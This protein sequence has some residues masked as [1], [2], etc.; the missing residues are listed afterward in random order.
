MKRYRSIPANVSVLASLVITFAGSWAGG[1]GG[2]NVTSG[3]G[4]GGNGAGELLCGNGKLDT[5]EECD[6][7]ALNDDNAVCTSTCKKTHCGDGVVNT[8]VEECDNGGYNADTAACTAWCN[9]AYCGDH[10]IQAGVEECDEGS[11]NG[12]NAPCSLTCKK[13]N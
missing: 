10:F 2:D 1:C 12:N 8:K 5:G 9:N 6:D 4:N 3:N 11:E 7:G 13:V